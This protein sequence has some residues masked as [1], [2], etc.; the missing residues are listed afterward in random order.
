MEERIRQQFDRYQTNGCNR[1][2]SD[3]CVFVQ[4]VSHHDMLSTRTLARQTGAQVA[5]IFAQL[6]LAE[7][8][9]AVAQTVDQRECQNSALG[10]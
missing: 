7:I 10:L 5:Q 4:R 1:V 8:P 3:Y 6:E 9:G 2:G